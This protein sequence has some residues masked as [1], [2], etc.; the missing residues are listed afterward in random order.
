MHPDDQNV[1]NDLK[2]WLFDKS[3]IR[4]SDAIA[5]QSRVS[6][7]AAGD[8][9]F[10]AGDRLSEFHFV[11]SGLVR[12][13][14]LT[15]D[16]RELNKSFVS[17]GGVATS[18]SSFL[19]DK[20]APFFVQSLEG[21]T[22]VSMPMETVR[23]LRRE[24]GEWDVLVNRLIS[25]LALKKERR[26]ASFLLRDAT[27]RYQDFLAEFGDVAPRLPQYHIAS[28][29]GITPVALSRIRSRLAATG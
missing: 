28:Y 18:L 13:Y 5:A 19:E 24:H 27:E 29:L 20:R 4:L 14:Y 7:R 15:K 12:Y 6:C 17:G 10:A 26:E 3:K 22:L 25:D 11:M 21:T 23:R 2:A 1:L 8:V 9:I 16:G